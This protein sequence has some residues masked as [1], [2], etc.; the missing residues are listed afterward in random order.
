LQGGGGHGAFTWGV[1]DR[2]VDEK[3]QV[4]AICGV[5]SG[6]PIGVMLAH[7]LICDGLTGAGGAPNNRHAGVAVIPLTS[8]LARRRYDRSAC[9]TAVAYRVTVKDSAQPCRM[10]RRQPW[11]PPCR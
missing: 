10:T 3:L 11:A 7:G 4:D 5:L 2:L 8:R 1:L 6:A 9:R